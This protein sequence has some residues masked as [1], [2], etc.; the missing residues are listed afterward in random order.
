MRNIFVRNKRKK[1]KYSSKKQRPELILYRKPKSPI[2]EA[3][4]T[5]RTNIQFSYT[6]RG[7]K[8]IVVTSSAPREGKTTTVINLGCAF[9]QANKKTL[10]IDSDLNVS[11]IPTYGEKTN[12]EST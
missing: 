10:I 1:Q 7:V 2:S 12:D 5:L 8:T 6:N 3:Y 11:L 4:R 9:A